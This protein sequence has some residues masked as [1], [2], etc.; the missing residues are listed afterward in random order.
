MHTYLTMYNVAIDSISKPIMIPII[1]PASSTTAPIT[2]P[3][4]SPINLLSFESL[5]III[6]LLTDTS[7]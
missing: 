5:T 1:I 2:T 7:N 4:I 6:I 3:T